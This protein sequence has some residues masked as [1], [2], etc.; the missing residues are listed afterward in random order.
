MKLPDKTVIDN[1]EHLPTVYRLMHENRWPR[2][3]AQQWLTDFMRWV[4]TSHRSEIENN[5]FFIMDNLH[6]LDDVWHAYIL[7]SRDYFK[8]SKELFD[9]EYIHHHPE[10]PFLISSIPDETT[11]YQMNMLKEDWGEA[12]IDRVWSYGAD[13]HD[14]IQASLSSAQSE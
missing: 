14:V 2:Q 10:N 4:Y 8:M 9:V 11:L 7:S 1:W 3:T 12:Y 6:Y 5:K 13:M